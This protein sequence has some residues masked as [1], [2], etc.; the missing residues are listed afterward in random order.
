MELSVSGVYGPESL[1]LL[2]NLGIKRFCFDLRP[3]SLN[4]LQE[5][6]L[7]QI[8]KTYVTPNEQ[9]LI[10][11]ENEKTYVV[12]KILADLKKSPVLDFSKQVSLE[13][14]DTQD[15][16][17]YE[18]FGVPY[19]WHFSTKMN[20]QE[21][22][23]A[24]NFQGF[25]FQLKDLIDWFQ[26]GSLYTFFKSLNDQNVHKKHFN[27]CLPIQSNIPESM[28]DFLNFHSIELLINKSVEDSYRN[29]NLEQLKSVVVG[30]R[31]ALSI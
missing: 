27:L 14:S 31:H 10:Q 12:E 18:Q 2:M 20:Y 16:E 4:F 29:I 7:H 22:F 3:L 15:V 28:L 5:Y 9:I 11:F 21:F 30:Y 25:I 13:F 23:H 19:Y 24:P 26:D 6:K 1:H 8:L 17:Y